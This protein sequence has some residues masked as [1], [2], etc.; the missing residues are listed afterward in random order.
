MLSY[1]DIFGRTMLLTGSEM[2]RRLRHDLHILVVGVGGVGSW[3]AEALVRSGLGHIT[4]V[5]SDTVAPS[6]I[7]RQLPATV[8]TVGEYKVDVLARHFATIN[9][10]IE[11]RAIAGRYNDTTAA[12]YDFESYDYIVDAID[13]LPAKALLI[14]NATAARR[15]VLF[16]SMGAARKLD[17][18]KIAVAEFWKVNGCALARALRTRFK[19]SEQFPRRKFKCVYSP[20]RLPQP[21]DTDGVNG[22]FMPATATFGLTLAAQILADIYKKEH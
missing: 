9:P 18:S 10:E 7:N 3:C 21:A 22:T 17:P 1:D 12:D 13:D 8:D 19:R 4:I 15:P 16:S 20:E 6:N 14:L 5:D 11:V 2:A